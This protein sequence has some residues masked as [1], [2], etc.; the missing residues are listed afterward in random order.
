MTAPASRVLSISL[1]SPP[2]SA[3][4]SP[5]AHTLSASELIDSLTGE[6]VEVARKG[7]APAW[8][9]FSYRG[10][11]R[12][13]SECL[14][15]C[16]LVYDLD[17][18]EA[19]GAAIE[20]LEARL[21]ERG[22]LYALHETYSP[23]RYRL[24]LPL[25]SDLAPRDYARAWTSVARA[26]EL[27]ALDTATGDL[28]R[29]YYAPSCPPG[30]SADRYASTGGGRLLDPSEIEG[31]PNP[32][33]CR[34]SDNPP[35]SLESAKP[36]TP[37]SEENA[38]G[39][40]LPEIFDLDAIRASLRARGTDAGKETLSAIEGKLVI[41]KGERD[42]TLLRL[43]GALAFCPPSCRLSAEGAWALLEPTVLR[44]EGASEDGAEHWKRKVIA[45]YERAMGNATRRDELA[46]AT[47]DF[48]TKGIEP[49]TGPEDDEPEGEEWRSALIFSTDAQG[50]AKSLKPLEANILEIL[51]HHKFFKGSVRF[52][53]LRR[54]IEVLGGPLANNP[55]ESLDTGLA[56][57]LQQSEFKCSVDRSRAAATL[58]HHSLHHPYDPVQEYLA[59]LPEWDGVNRI[60][61]VL[62]RLAQAV[63]N[64]E[65]IQTVTRKFFIAAVARAMRPGCQVDTVLVLQ[66]AQGGGKTSFVRT[67]GAGFSVET[68]LDIHN[69]DAVM[70]STGN[71]LVELSELA[72]LKRGDVE[73][74]RAFITNKEDQIRL[75]YGR[76]VEAFPRRCVFVGTTNAL[77]P[78]TDQEGNRRFWVVSVGIVD[79]QALLA[80]REQ[81]WAEALYAYRSGE[82][83]WLDRAQQAQADE[84]A[85][86]YLVEDAVEMAL[87][88]WL[89]EQKT[90]P[91][92][93]TA[94]TV[95]TKALLKPPGA[96]TNVDLQSISRAMARMGF[97]RS[98]RR[99][100]GIPSVVYLLDGE[101]SGD[102]NVADKGE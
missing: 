35:K 93:L 1:Y 71:W 91:E 23:G 86:A 52:N 68:K 39:N 57:W 96:V 56:I 100:K 45:Q 53:V 44:M 36:A 29:L 90:K 28:A 7:D 84:E 75:P 83:W 42:N 47:H 6:P 85:K 49:G 19:D 59:D 69:K 32:L 27:P 3:R 65:W 70:V 99:I 12:T 37:R 48:L 10:S 33:G 8:S 66:G 31:L 81:L 41:R 5:V 92:F 78:L 43:T 54:R 17:S 13:A 24:A 101:G 82:E 97:Q 50:Q 62:L 2:D 18:E 16:A 76:T 46:Q 34:G 88:Q 58:L 87:T 15:A 4:S 9:P 89:S 73:S 60:D 25:A 55:Q 77:Q 40:Q 38:P 11:R 51:R 21:L 20:A 22:H 95:A 30:E 26:L 74:V 94:M 79:T 14:G 102:D 64:P 67:I 80:E 63:G 98:R 61:S 72:S